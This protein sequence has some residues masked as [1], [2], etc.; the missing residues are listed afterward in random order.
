MLS[1]HYFL[2]IESLSE[3]QCGSLLSRKFYLLFFI[4]NIVLCYSWIK[5]QISSLLHAIQ[6]SWVDRRELEYISVPGFF[7]PC[8]LCCFGRHLKSLHLFRLLS[9]IEKSDKTA[10]IIVFFLSLSFCKNIYLLFSITL[11]KTTE[12]SSLSVRERE[13]A[14]LCRWAGN[15]NQTVSP[16]SFLKHL[17]RVLE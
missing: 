11:S 2:F 1:N 4:I 13:I 15:R 3:L 17:V 12:A 5:N 16:L 7:I 14:L 8:S 10:E 6:Q 9:E